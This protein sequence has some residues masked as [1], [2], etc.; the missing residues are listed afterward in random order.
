MSK[1]A[2]KPKPVREVLPD[3]ATLLPLD[4]YDYI[5]VA[6]SGGKDSMACVLHL[7]D[8]GIAPERIELWHYCVDGKPGTQNIWDWPIT[9]SYCKAFSYAMNIPLLLHWKEGGLM[10]EVLRDKRP[11]AP[12]TITRG[13]GSTVTAGGDGRLN[14]RLY[15][16]QLSKTPEGRYCS[17]YVKMDVAAKVFSNDPRF[18]GRK[19]LMLTG[20]R[21]EESNARAVYAAVTA[22]KS[23]TQ[24]RR[25]D[26]WRP[27]LDWSEERVWEIM[28][29]YGVN[30]HPAY[31]LGWS[32]LSCMTCIYGK[33]DQWYTIRQIAPQIFDYFSQYEKIL[34]RTVDRD[35]DVATKAD[36]GKSTI[37]PKYGYLVALALQTH[38][39][40]E[41]MLT[42]PGQKWW[43]PPG[44]FHHTGGPT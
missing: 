3:T 23:T 34:N 2:A 1:K 8:L 35:V 6:F 20:E 38:F 16:P 18:K 13:D 30:P 17:S 7:L 25:V 43:M 41:Y 44:A 42:A 28:Q 26:H 5:I 15:W 29:R 36:A 19:S 37:D 4:E 21:R 33:P 11:T 32:R 31:Y 39:P 9:E 10:G 22:D 27:V 24:N 40:V 14:S 12:T